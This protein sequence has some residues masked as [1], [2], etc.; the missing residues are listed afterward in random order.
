MFCSGPLTPYAWVNSVIIG[1]GNGLLPVKRQAITWTNP[2][3]LSNTHIGTNFIGSLIK[4]K[5]KFYQENAFEYVICKMSSIF[6]RSQRVKNQ[7]ICGKIR[8]W[9]Y[10]GTSFV[11]SL[12]FNLLTTMVTFVRCTLGTS[13]CCLQSPHVCVKKKVATVMLIFPQ[14]WDWQNLI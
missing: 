13:S 10:F 2:D 7:W 4:L 12:R 11:S 3:L 8:T 14:H 9:V 1:K 6:F 5:K